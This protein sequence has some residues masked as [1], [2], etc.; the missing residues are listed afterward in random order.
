MSVLL[1]CR[2]A[3]ARIAPLRRGTS[4]RAQPI[5]EI[6]IRAYLD[7]SGDS[8]NRT[9]THLT[10]GGFVGTMRAWVEVDRRWKE[11]LSRW[12][13]GAIHMKDASAL[14]GEFSPAKGWTQEKVR[15]LENDIANTCLGP[16]GWA[17]H[18]DEF[19]GAHCTVHLADYRRACHDF[20]LRYGPDEPEA[21]CV[22]RVVTTALAA[23]PE[24]VSAP[25]GKAGAV[26]LFFDRNERFMRTIDRVWRRHRGDGIFRHIARIECAS[27]EETGIQAADF[28]AWH[29][30]RGHLDGNLRFKTMAFMLSPGEYHYADYKALAKEY[31]RRT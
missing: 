21:F 29:A 28:V 4:S 25:H 1:R 2:S 7:G 14:R 17:T 20:N 31:G 23:L 16:V 18:R 11:M 26:E 3:F 5:L 8:R 13:C 27:A 6:A 12:G 30:R 24:D 22:D 10:L 19:Y 15:R 9:E